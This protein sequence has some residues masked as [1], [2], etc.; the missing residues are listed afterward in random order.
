MVLTHY[1]TVIM[2]DQSGWDHSRFPLHR[3]FS[4]GRCDPKDDMHDSLCYAHSVEYDVLSNK[5]RPLNL[6]SDAWCSSGSMLSDGR[7]IRMGGFGSGS[8]R[9]HYFEPCGNVSRC[10]WKEWRKVLAER[11]WLASSVRLAESEDRVIVLGGRNA[12]SYEF[13]PKRFPGER[14]FHLPFLQKTYE[15]EEGGNNLYPIVHL[16]YDN[17]LFIFANRDSILFNYKRSA[18]VKTFPRIHGKGSRSYPSTG[19]S[20]ILPLDHNDGFAKTEVMICGG[21]T[22]G[23]FGAAKRG[24]FLMG[25]STCGRMVITGNIHVWRM[26]KMP[27]ARLMSDM[28]I[29]QNGHIL[30]INGVK[31]GSAGVHYASDPALEPY[32]YDPKKIHDLKIHK[33]CKNAVLVSNPFTRW[34]SSCCRE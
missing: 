23:A 30:I 33:N 8:R 24:Q 20:V 28:I 3:R 22:S 14:S 13:V 29:L 17:H 2:F 32:L 5:I 34:K 16:S 7:L 4:G 9:I 11:R 26:E 6:E 18:V 25:M 1:N 31:N 10:Y 19:S 21:A 27:E 15:A 12:F